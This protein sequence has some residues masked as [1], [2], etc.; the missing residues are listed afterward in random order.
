MIIPT[1]VT[2]R[3]NNVL[4]SVHEQTIAAI[5]SF[6]LGGIVADGKRMVEDLRRGMR[7]WRRARRRRDV[8]VEEVILWLVVQGVKGNKTRRDAKYNLLS[9]LADT[10][11]CSFKVFHFFLPELFIM[12][13]MCRVAIL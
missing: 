5:R 13:Y 10:Y 2:Q 12:F 11:P 9:S 6:A 7:S 1:L 3:P 8:V 4:Y